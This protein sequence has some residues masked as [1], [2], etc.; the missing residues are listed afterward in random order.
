ML[1]GSNGM[2]AGNS[3]YEAIFQGICELF[4]RYAAS[5]VFIID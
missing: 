4:E 2:S 1:T 3:S 5:E